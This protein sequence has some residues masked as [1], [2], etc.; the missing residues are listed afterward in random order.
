MAT[1]TEAVKESLLGSTIEPQLTVQAKAVF[2]KHA[3][4][5]EESGELYMTE[6]DFVNAIAPQEEDYVRSSVLI[7]NIETNAF[8]AQDQARAV[9]YLVQRR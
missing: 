6:D 3:R 1:V 4:R 7:G 9:R 5:D 2:E 8:L